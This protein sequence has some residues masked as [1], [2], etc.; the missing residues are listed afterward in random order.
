MGRARKPSLDVVRVEAALAAAGWLSTPLP[1]LHGLSARV[2]LVPKSYGDDVGRCLLDAVDASG[3]EWDLLPA[4]FGIVA[5]PRVAH[6]MGVGL[7][8]T[9]LSDASWVLVPVERTG[10][11]GDWLH[12]ADLLIGL[13]LPDF[14]GVAVFTESWGA[15]PGLQ[16]APSGRS[17]DTV[18][19]REARA[20]HWAWKSTPNAPMGWAVWERG[21]AAPRVGEGAVGWTPALMR[22]VLGGPLPELVP[23]EVVADALAFVLLH[24]AEQVGGVTDPSASD[25]A[26]VALT[27][28][29][30]TSR[31]RL[32]AA[33]QDR[34][35]LPDPYS[36]WGQLVTSMGGP[37][38]AV[39]VTATRDSIAWLGDEVSAVAVARNPSSDECWRMV[40]TRSMLVDQVHCPTSEAAK[41]LDTALA[42]VA[43]TC[44]DIPDELTASIVAQLITGEPQVVEDPEAVAN[45]LAENYDDDVITRWSLGNPDPH[46]RRVALYVVAGQCQRGHLAEVLVEVGGVPDQLARKVAGAYDALNEEVADTVARAEVPTWSV[47][48]RRIATVAS[49]MR[50]TFVDESADR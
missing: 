26:A 19:A 43:R 20:V 5:A 23:A 33:V 13:S 3:A 8:E 24:S 41:S 45:A 17:A 11:R 40:V 14:D 34:G 31:E 32:R 35:W 46:T 49:R 30:L 4:I 9:A 36:D 48:M 21:D 16:I 10:L 1:D 44:Q 6:L 12:Y 29:G 2:V 25:E 7:E 50:F 47:P 15:A 27:L 18:G 37:V 38:D 42:A 22:A 39:P 28:A